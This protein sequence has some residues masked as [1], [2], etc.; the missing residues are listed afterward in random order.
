MS[1][2]IIQICLCSLN[3]NSSPLSL[4]F[5]LLLLQQ[6][7][8]FIMV[9]SLMFYFLPICL[10]LSSLFPCWSHLKYMLYCFN[11]TLDNAI[12]LIAFL[13]YSLISSKE[14]SILNVCGYVLSWCQLSALECS[15]RKSHNRPDW[16]HCKPTITTLKWCL[17][18]CLVISSPF[19]GSAPSLLH[20][21]PQWLCH[22]FSIL[23]ERLFSSLQLYK[24]P[25]QKEELYKEHRYIPSGRIYIFL[26]CQTI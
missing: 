2:A 1:K 5:K 17:L 23:L 10:P 12:N 22:K 9:S 15:P 26:R 24:L 3:T 16:L 8:D 6:F 4:L 14:T 13:F 18:H 11:D 7:F 19:S 20:S 21:P 25:L